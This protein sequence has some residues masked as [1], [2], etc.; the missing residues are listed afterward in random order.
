MD[1]KDY[2]P[3]WRYINDNYDDELLQILDLSP[4]MIRLITSNYCPY[5]CSFCISTNFLKLASDE[6]KVRVVGA[7]AQEL[8]D[9]CVKILATDPEIFIYFD[10]ENFLAMPQRAKQFCEA[11]IE[12]GIDGH[13]GCRATAQMITDDICALM[14]KAG[15]KVVAF[16]AE[17]WDGESLKDFNKRLENDRSDIAIRNIL[18]NHMKCSFNIILFAPKIT[19]DG[20]IYTCDKILKYVGLECNVGIT[21]FI[22][23]YPGTHYF[24]NDQYVI[25]PGEITVPGTGQ[26]LSHPQAVL[27]SDEYLRDIAHRAQARGAEILSFWKSEFQWKH[28]IMPREVSCLA[29]IYA[30]YLEL[31]VASQNDR[32]NQIMQ[33]VASI[34]GNQRNN[35]VRIS[36]PPQDLAK[37]LRIDGEHY[38]VENPY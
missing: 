5:G 17:S 9:K 32:E 14:Y 2:Q 23:P 26:V 34:L 22:A 36:R 16:G 30:V 7:S 28:P 18:N 37:H 31:D 13:F 11:I 4:K 27:P 8:V 33:I 25:V 19:R 24:D 20:L 15:F 3:Y 21:T 12:Q 29:L 6:K 1:V 38:A 35:F 10:D